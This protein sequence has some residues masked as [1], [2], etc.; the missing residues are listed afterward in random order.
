MRAIRG[1]SLTTIIFSLFM[2]VTV[3]L[4]FQQF[5]TRM[6]LYAY[7]AMEIDQLITV[8]NNIL[9]E[10]SIFQRNETIDCELKIGNRSY[11]LLEKDQVLHFYHTQN[12]EEVLSFALTE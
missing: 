10:P 5:Q 12:G 9:N 4:G 11:R 1:S 3:I 6:A 2:I 8:A 7:R